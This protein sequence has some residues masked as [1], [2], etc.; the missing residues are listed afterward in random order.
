MTH[1][2]TE[3]ADQLVLINKAIQNGVTYVEA[4]CQLAGQK[5]GAEQDEALQKAIKVVADLDDFT[6]SRYQSK[7]ADFL[8]ISERDLKRM[9]KSVKDDEKKR[10]GGE[11]IIY[12]MGGY[13]DGYVVDYMYDPEDQQPLLC[14]REP[15]DPKGENLKV[16]YELNI[17]GKRYAA[18]QPTETILEGGILLPSKLG[19]KQTTKELAD[20]I[21]LFMK[22]VYLFAN[23]L[24]PKIIAY[25]VMET[26]L[27][28][29]F[30]AVSYLR[31]TGEP[32]S[33]KSELMKRIGLL[34]YRTINSSG[35][36]STSS[37]FRMVERYNPTVLMDEMDLKDSSASADIVKFLTL[38]AMVD[39]AIFRTEKMMIDGK[40]VFVE[41]MFRTY[42]PK[43]IAMQGAMFKDPAVDSRCLTF[44]VQPR[45]SYE[46][47][48]AGIPGERTK[49]MRDTALALRNMLL[50]WR[51]TEWQPQIEINPDFINE[52]I[53]PRL[54][55]ITGPLMMVAKNEPELRKEINHFMNEY[56]LFLIQD[57][58]M[59]IE[60][61]IIEALWK[62][63]LSPTLHAEMVE[64]E[65]GGIEKIKVGHVTQIANDIM[66]EM[67]MDD[68]EEQE[69]NIKKKSGNVV[70]THKIGRRMRNILQLEIANR[71]TK[72][73]FVIWQEEKMRAISNR[74]GVKP[75]DVDLTVPE[76]KAPTV[77]TY[78]QGTN[79]S[80]FQKSFSKNEKQGSFLEDKND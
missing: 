65:P 55:Q 72:G 57:K 53:S 42:C 7:F 20:M 71:S 18:A 76:K 8:N 67:N 29:C 11:D 44:Q 5:Q 39:G 69:S 3:V 48:K 77:S 50:T 14:C 1:K 9:L 68:D 34:C 4:I 25:Y 10:G 36:S 51:L 19:P 35:A 75:E 70:T 46:L 21:E 45:E 80:Q 13:I 64:R 27:F 23:P 6:R 49:A 58:T 16:D 41:T 17:N 33:G 22:S 40:E 2:K 79:Q 73:F 47:K 60:A 52:S 61:R 32:G 78:G 62:I 59:S 28:D 24:F 63:Y 31:A 26:W 12:T 15:N 38:G 74:Y 37:L 56:N 66:R 54:N 43:L 30:S